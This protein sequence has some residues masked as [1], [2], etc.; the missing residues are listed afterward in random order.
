MQKLNQT[1][2]FTPRKKSSFEMDFDELYDFLSEEEEQNLHAQ[3]LITFEATQDEIDTWA[4]KLETQNAQKQLQSQQESHY[5]NSLTN[6]FER[7]LSLEKNVKLSPSK[8][9]C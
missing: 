2:I 3:N 1:N 4:K 9:C 6:G 8:F 5:Q 7:K